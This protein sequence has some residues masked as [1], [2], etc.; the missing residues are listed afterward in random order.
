MNQKVFE[1]TVSM[2][3]SIIEDSLRNVRASKKLINAELTMDEYQAVPDK[4]FDRQSGKL[5]VSDNGY[6]EQ[7]RQK[8]RQALKQKYIH[9]KGNALGKSVL[10]DLKHSCRISDY[11]F[12]VEPEL[13]KY[14]ATSCVIFFDKAFMENHPDKEL[15][16]KQVSQKIAAK[17]AEFLI[18]KHSPY[19]KYRKKFLE[20]FSVNGIRN[21]LS[22]S[23]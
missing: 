4:Y 1:H 11:G 5:I 21:R 2:L 15:L 3:T 18:E 20:G 22:K 7:K 13:E 19:H 16:V 23:L 8:L 9:N 10:Q 14:V 17:S 6:S 12:E